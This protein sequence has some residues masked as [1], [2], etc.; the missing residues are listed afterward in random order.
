A[1]VGA[2]SDDLPAAAAVAGL[3]LAIRYRP[4]AG[5][6]PS[7]EAELAGRLSAAIADRASGAGGLMLGLAALRDAVTTVDRYASGG[8]ER[9]LLPAL[10][11]PS[12]QVRLAAG[13][14]LLRR[15]SPEALLDRVEEWIAQAESPTADGIQ[16]QLG[17]ALWFCPFLREADPAGR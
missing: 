9:S 1:L 4:A 17:L 7:A 6:D 16:H 15:R 3:C 12:F 2:L 11:S 14:A 13:L 8:P 5:L 10:P